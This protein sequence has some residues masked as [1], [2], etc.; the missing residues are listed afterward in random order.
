[1]LIIMILI[2]AGVIAIIAVPVVWGKVQTGTVLD[3]P[4]DP[5]SS[6]LWQKES[7]YAAIRELE[8]DYHTGKISEDDY[9]ELYGSLKTDALRAIKGIEEGESEYRKKLDAELEEEIKEQRGLR[10]K[11][12]NEGVGEAAVCPAC[13]S[14]AAPGS[15]FCSS[16]GARFGWVCAECGS[17]NSSQAGFCRNCG[18]QSLKYCPECGDP[19]EVGAVFCANCGSALSEAG[20]MKT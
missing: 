11:P 18:A 13:G 3:D 12:G 9:K 14:R 20:G 19:V 5:Q 17:I 15:K 4:E 7:S 10:T 6:L 16:C 8:F 2:V 1:M